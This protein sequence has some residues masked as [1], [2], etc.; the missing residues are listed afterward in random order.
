MKIP[1]T[2]NYI[3]VQGFI[4]FILIEPT[5][6]YPSQITEQMKSTIDSILNVVTN[7]NYKNDKKVRRQLIRNLIDQRFS[8]EQMSMRSLSKNWKN[9]S[10]SEQRE[11]IQL[12]SKLLEN[13]YVRKIGRNN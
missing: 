10:R 8:Y 4:L 1:A 12:F 5:L 2:W 7:D 6:V 13:F 3:L 11:F 9:I